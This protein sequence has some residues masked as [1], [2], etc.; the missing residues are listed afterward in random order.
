MGFELGTRS[1]QRL[2]LG[3]HPDLYRVVSRAIEITPIDFS[4]IEGRRSVERQRELVA[5][6][7]SQTMNSRHITGH[8]VDL[9]AYVAGSVQ[10]EWALYPPIADAMR[11]AALELGIPVRWGG[12]WFLLNDCNSL[13]GIEL[14]V[15]A[16]TAA[17]RAQKRKAF[18]DGPHF[19]LPASLYP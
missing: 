4:V 5:K 7:A 18:L 11:R 12:G 16:Y 6:G 19:E 14:K 9:G 17:R 3:V 1:R 8:A 15:A 2:N 13:R 10:W